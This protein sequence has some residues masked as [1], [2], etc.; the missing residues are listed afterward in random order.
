MGHICE[1][2]TNGDGDEN[3]P[4]IQISQFLDELH[5]VDVAAQDSPYLAGRVLSIAGRMASYL[6][7]DQVESY[8]SAAVS[9][10]PTD[11]R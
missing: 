6:S 1:S 7:A 11:E 10:K 3:Q 4:P 9:G 2:F 8:I 5:R